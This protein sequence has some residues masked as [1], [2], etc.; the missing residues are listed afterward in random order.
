MPPLINAVHAQGNKQRTVIVCSAYWFM[1]LG[2]E[3]IELFQ[4]DVRVCRSKK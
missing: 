2:L 3:V 4:S 1:V